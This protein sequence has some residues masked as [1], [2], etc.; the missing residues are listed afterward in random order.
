MDHTSIHDLRKTSGETITAPPG[1]TAITSGRLTGGLLIP[2]R[3]ADPDRLKAVLAKLE[4]LVDGRDRTRDNADM[5]EVSI[6]STDWTLAA[7]RDLQ[8]F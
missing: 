4:A 3:S 7:I 2:F 6:D 8:A 1:G 5:A